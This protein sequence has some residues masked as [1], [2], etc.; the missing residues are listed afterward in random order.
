MD[1]CELSHLAVVDLFHFHDCR[2]RSIGQGFG[3]Q[4]LNERPQYG[5]CAEEITPRVVVTDPMLGDVFFDIPLVA[6]EVGHVFRHQIDKRLPAPNH[7]IYKWLID[8]H[9]FLG[10]TC[11]G[12]RWIGKHE[13]DF[14]VVGTREGVD[15]F[16]DF[17]RSEIG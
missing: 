10:K 7:E 17:L 16:D 4:H 12:S 1:S 15:L 3:T 5:M 8:P 11:D 6:R 9:A 14:L 13:Q 2:I